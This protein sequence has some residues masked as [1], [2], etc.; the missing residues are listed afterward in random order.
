MI[1]EAFILHKN[2]WEQYT[3]CP[4]LYLHW[5]PQVVSDTRGI[6]PDF[7]LGCYFPFPPHVYLQGG[8][9]VKRVTPFMINLP[10]CNI[11]GKDESVKETLWA[12]SFQARDQ[13]KA[14]VK[15]G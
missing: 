10:P 5:N 2:P 12:R 13:A 7:G 1:T 14:A 11:I 9:E 15:G 6:L 3:I 8:A 4:Q